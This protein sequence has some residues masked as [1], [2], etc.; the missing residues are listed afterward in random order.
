MR[1][2]RLADAQHR[3]VAMQLVKTALTPFQV[4][5]LR[6]MP[7]GICN[8][9]VVKG[10]TWHLETDSNAVAGCRDAKANRNTATSVALLFAEAVALARPNSGAREQ[11]HLCQM[12]KR[13]GWSTWSSAL[14]T[15]R[16]MC[17]DTVSL[18]DFAARLALPPKSRSGP[19][20]FSKERARMT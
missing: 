7:I 12:T 15:R 8:E 5:A 13:S 16:I 20:C 19:G 10:V 9:A 2:S 3:A 1:L 4:A 18:H 11:R 17:K 14:T 6:L